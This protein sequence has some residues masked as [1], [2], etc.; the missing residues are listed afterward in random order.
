MI[1]LSVC[2]KNKHQLLSNL[3]ILKNI[4]H[5]VRRRIQKYFC[6]KFQFLPYLVIF[7]ISTQIFYNDSYLIKF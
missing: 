6:M 2:R 7:G 4:Q 5:L 3:K 1:I